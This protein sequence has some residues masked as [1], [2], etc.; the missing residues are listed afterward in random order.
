MSPFNCPGRPPITQT[1]PNYSDMGHKL[2]YGGN[3]SLH[4]YDYTNLSEYLRESP[5][6]G[7]DVLGPS[8]P[9]TPGVN[10]QRRL[11]PHVRVARGCGTRGQLCHPGQRH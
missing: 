6:G 3:A 4:T 7:S 8:N 11:G 5:I 1:Q 9:Q 2:S 10:H